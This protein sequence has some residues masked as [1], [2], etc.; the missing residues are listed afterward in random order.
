MADSQTNRKIGSIINI[1]NMV[2]SLLIGLL[3][4]PLLIRHLGS[5]EYGTYTL[6]Q[7]TIAYLSILDLGL[8]NALVRYVSRIRT[9]REEGNLIG[10][11]LIFY[12]T[13]AAISAIIGC[14]LSCN[15]GTFFSGSFNDTEV[16]ILKHVFNVLLINTVISFP[17]T[18][19]SSVIRSYE[20]FI[21]AN[22]LNLTQNILNHAIM[23]VLLMSG[24]KSVALAI[25]SLISTIIIAC[26]N[27][28]YCYRILK[29][30]IRFRCFEKSFYYEV[31]VYSAFVFINIIVDQLY[32]STDKIILGKVCG[33]ISVAVYGVGVTFQQY[34]TQFSTSISSVFLPHISK[35]SV[36]KEA[37]NEIS[38]VFLKVGHI[39]LVLLS[40]ICVGFVVYGQSFIKLW[41][42]E[43]YH[44][45][46]YI[47]LLVMVPTLIPLSQNIGISILQALNKHRIR[48]VMYLC[49]ALIN[50]VISIPLTIRFGG[51][52]ASIGT[53]IGNLLGQILF[54]NWFY[55]K[56]IGIDIPQYWR[57]FCFLLTKL[58]PVFIVFLMTLLI[59]LKGWEG[60]MVKICIGLLFVLPYYYRFILSVNEKNMVIDLLR[61]CIIFVRK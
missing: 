24:F 42:G 2:C 1:L 32:A 29:I 56:K 41:A 18:V 33:S 50:V 26:V 23:I 58:L 17:T 44:D 40:L 51:I 37:M 16:R 11:F 46:Y 20:K 54:M 39:Q 4:T 60:L 10:M 8:G 48:S 14:I 6:A 38:T 12:S 55:W 27:I 59:P 36:R 5:N 15:I 61:H 57:N 30:K 19:F 35:L 13:I 7:S 45:A 21:F 43:E 22:T 49:I 25:V 34:F 31:L 28:T 53:A 47:A 52:G 9:E 3:Y